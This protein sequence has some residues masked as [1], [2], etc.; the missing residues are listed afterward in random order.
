MF[1]LNV[2]YSSTLDLVTEFQEKGLRVYADLL[3]DLD[4]LKD[5]PL[6]G[7]ACILLSSK[8]IG[9]QTQVRTENYFTSVYKYKN[10][11]YVNETK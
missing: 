10:Y 8:S 1:F 9:K 6:D 11:V 3:T 7:D 4:S 2:L 5:L